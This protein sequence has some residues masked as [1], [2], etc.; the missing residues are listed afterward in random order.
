[1]QARLSTWRGVAT[2]LVCG[3]GAAA[4]VL[5]GV[6]AASAGH[7]TAFARAATQRSAS[8]NGANE[9]PGPG[10]PNGRGH[11]TVTLRPGSHKVC[12]TATWHRIG[13]P[14]AAHI[15]KG[16]R[17]VEGPVKVDLSS[18]VTGGSHCK[19]GVSTALIHRISNHPRNFY[20]NIHTN[21]FQSGAI[22]GQL[23]R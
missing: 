7:H 19:G 20:F 18:A 2:G 6:Q 17:G 3:V 16:A 10:D 15:H 21:Q 22:R 1:M 9:V 4:L 5:V 13:T 11:A 12:V 8:L 14:L 23:H